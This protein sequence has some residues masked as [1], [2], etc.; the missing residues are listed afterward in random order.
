MKVSRRNLLRAGVAVGVAA[1]AGLTG[2]AA[3]DRRPLLGLIAPPKDYPVPPEALALYGSQIRFTV[4]GLGLPTMTPAGYDSVI[5]KIVPA[6]VQQGKSGAN[7]ISI[8]GTSLTFYK[9]AAFNQKLID[10]VHK[11]TGLPTTSMSTA[12]VEGLKAVNGKRIA[13]ATAYNDEVNRRL[14]TFLEESGFQ[15]LALKGLGLESIADPAKVTQAKLQ[16]F[17]ED[18]FKT[19][20]KADALFVSCGG[21][22]TLEIVAP[23]E[24][25]CRVPVVSSTPHAL[26]A[27]MRILGLHVKAPAYGRLLANG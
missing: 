26:W 14:H 13:V 21:L 17:S 2:E 15:V 20:P 9:G 27:G 16:Q 1:S 4:Y 18:V 6:A 3:A 25:D 23:L 24:R 19:A 10:D 7:A 5:D 22:R 8:F 11:A 12:I